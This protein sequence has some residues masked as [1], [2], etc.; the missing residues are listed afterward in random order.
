VNTP[1]FDWVLHRGVTHHPQ[2]VPPIYQPEMPAKVI[3]HTLEHPR[4]QVL[5]GLPTVATIW[6]NR[7]APRLLDRYL[8]RGNVEAQQNPAKDPPGASSNLW[9]P[10]PG[11]HGAHGSF[12]DSAH[13]GTPTALPAS[14]GALLGWAG[15][16]AV[17]AA[18]GSAIRRVRARN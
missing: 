8:A 4:R 6:A 12:D 3:V 2:P 11:D 13:R 9:E 10:L 18:A 15:A 16:G 14:H 5:V 1:Q 7:L 17:L